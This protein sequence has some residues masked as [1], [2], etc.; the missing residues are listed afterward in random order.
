MLAGGPGTERFA[1]G[2]VATGKSSICS[3]SRT[4]H[5]RTISLLADGS[6]LASV[7]KT[8]EI[9]LRNSVTGKEAHRLKGHG[10][11]ISNMAFSPDGKLLASKAYDRS[12]RLW[13]VTEGREICKLGSLEPSTRGNDAASPIAFAADGKSV[14]A[15]TVSQ[16]PLSG[17]QPRTFH[18][19]NVPSG[20]VVPFL[21]T[22]RHG[23]PHLPGKLWLSPGPK[24]EPSH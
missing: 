9:V 3:T 12:I 23:P 13:D 4:G 20:S 21:M 24:Q 11:P 1:F 18:V 10:G 7:G 16:N 17:S 15:A 6:L 19:W 8:S 22:R 14:I 2:N 5:V